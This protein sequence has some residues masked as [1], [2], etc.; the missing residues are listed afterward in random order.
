ME[1]P[2][3]VRVP[4]AAQKKKKT[5]ETKFQNQLK[6]KWISILHKVNNHIKQIMKEI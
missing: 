5:I 3:F 4:T 6:V 2:I 1:I